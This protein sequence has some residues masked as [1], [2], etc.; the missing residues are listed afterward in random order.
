L[1]AM[2]NPAGSSA[3]ELMR[4]P[5][6]S[7]DWDKPNFLF[8]DCNAHNEFSAPIFDAIRVTSALATANL[9]VWR[10]RG[11]L[12]PGF[13]TVFG[14]MLPNQGCALLARW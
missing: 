8:T 12:P 11:I 10:L 6:E 3:A 1:V 9:H 7:R 5:V 13:G 14:L 2:V 4:L